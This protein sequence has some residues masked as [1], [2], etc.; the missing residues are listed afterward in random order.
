MLETRLP[1]S[2]NPIL[3]SDMGWQY[4]HRW[5]RE[6]LAGLNIRQSMSRKDNYIDNAATEQVFGHLKDEFY[7]RP[8]IL[9]LRGVQDRT[10]GVHHPLEYQT[11]TGKKLE[12]HTPEEFRSMSLTD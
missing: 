8:R 7:T 2:A 9:L 11:K 10:G 4:Q 3:H 1:D 12:G 5:W 6:R